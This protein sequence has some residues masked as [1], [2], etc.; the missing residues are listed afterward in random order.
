MEPIDTKSTKLEIDPENMPIVLKTPSGNKFILDRRLN[1]IPTYH[2]DDS[3]KLITYI[4]IPSKNNDDISGRI[5]FAGSQNN[6]PSH[7]GVYTMAQLLLDP[8]YEEPVWGGVLEIRNHNIRKI[9]DSDLYGKAG[10][11][12]DY[13]TFKSHDDSEIEQRFIEEIKSQYHIE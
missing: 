2:I 7:E 3:T 6:R 5:I 13:T 11:W 4:Y 10:E 9:Y 8:N 1:Q 12:L